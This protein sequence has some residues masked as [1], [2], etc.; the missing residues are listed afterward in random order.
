MSAPRA[1]GPIPVLQVDAFTER[2]FGGNP[3]GVVL[4]AGALDTRAMQRVAAELNLPGT[5]FV[6]AP[7]HEDAQFGVRFF[8]P[9]REVTYSGHT[10][11]AVA[12]ALME[13]GRLASGQHLVLDTLGGLLQ[14]DVED[15]RG[16]ALIWLRPPLPALKPL[17]GPLEPLLELLRLPHDGLARWAQAA[18][19]PEADLLVPVARLERLREIDPDMARLGETAKRRGLRGICAVTRETIDATSLTH[20]RFFAPHFG[21]PEDIVTGSVHSAIGVWMLEHR[22]IRSAGDRI[23]FTGEQGDALGRPGRVEVELL[24]AEGKLVQSSV[25]GR[26]VTVLS[27]SLRGDW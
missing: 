26:A 13:A 1:A 9:L 10:T 27:G 24:L 21:I 16:R 19:T 5:G 3:A 18:V 4:D 22:Q 7:P 14:V 25:A 12:H 20:S 11:L 15:D 6:I 23:R 17:Q 2:P 8:T